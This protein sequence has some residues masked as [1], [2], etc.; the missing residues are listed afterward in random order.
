MLN[1]IEKQII[2]TKIKYKDLSKSNYTSDQTQEG[3]P[4]FKEDYKATSKSFVNLASYSLSFDTHNQTASKS[5]KLSIP[6]DLVARVKKMSFVIL[7]QATAQEIDKASNNDVRKAIAF[8]VVVNATSHYKPI[9]KTKDAKL[10]DQKTGVACWSTIQQIYFNI[11]SKFGTLAILEKAN[12]QIEILTRGKVAEMVASMTAT[13]IADKKAKAQA[14]AN[15]KAKATEQAKAKAEKQ[16]TQGKK[17]PS[18]SKA[19][20]KA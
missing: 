18:T 14:K 7:N 16:A 8:A 4:T 5:A 1:K 19:K 6:S 13:N 3:Q 20:A 11:L 10:Y 2:N 15:A 17:K 9:I 12:G